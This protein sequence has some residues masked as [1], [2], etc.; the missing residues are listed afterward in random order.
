MH[1]YSESFRGNLLIYNNT[2]YYNYRQVQTTTKFICIKKFVNNA[3][4]ETVKSSVNNNSHLNLFKN[5]SALSKKNPHIS[6]LAKIIPYIN[7]PQ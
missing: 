3:R 2:L 5:F 4:V 6:F 7:L 1:V